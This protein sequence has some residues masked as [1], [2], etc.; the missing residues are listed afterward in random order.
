MRQRGP[1]GPKRGPLFDY[2]EVFYNGQRR[3]SALAYLSPRV[4]E[5]RCEQEVASA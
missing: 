1:R 4:F 3:H 5:Q 2:L